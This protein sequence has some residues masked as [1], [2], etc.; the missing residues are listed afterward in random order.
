[1]KITDYEKVTLTPRQQ[2]SACGRGR[3]DKNNS[4]KGFACGT[5]GG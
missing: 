3:R 1:M 5:R 2:C 4:R